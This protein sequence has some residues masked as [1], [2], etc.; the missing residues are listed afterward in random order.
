[1]RSAVPLLSAPRTSL[2]PNP[3]H[4]A[5]CPPA[6]AL[7]MFLALCGLP[8]VAQ[9][10]VQGRVLDA[11][12]DEP[13]PF[14]AVHLPSG[15]HGVGT[16]LGGRFTLWVPAGADSLRVA[17]MGYRPA[18]VAV[19]DSMLVRLE[20]AVEQLRA[21]VVRPGEN[22]ALRLVEGAIAAR[23]RNH[24]PGRRAHRY[25][26]YG[27][28]VF[29]LAV[30]SA[31]LADSTRIA[32]LPPDDRQA[33]RFAQRQH[34]L[35]MESAT[36]CTARPPAQRTEE[37]LAMR[38]SGLKD[39]ALL[40]MAASSRTWSIYDPL[41]E[42]N[43]RRFPSP[44]AP[45]AT[46]RYRYVL[47]DTLVQ[48]G[49]TVF[50]IR[51][52]PRK[53]ARFDG[54]RGVLGLH[55]GDHAVHHVEA[56]PA[57]QREGLGMRMRQVHRRVGDTWFPEQV[58]STLFLNALKVGSYALVGRVRMDLTDIELD[59]DLP[60]SAF[61]GAD[62]V[63]DRMEVR[64]DAALWDSLRTVPLDAKDL[65]TYRT[66]DSLGRAEKL[67]RTVRGLDALLRGAIPWGPV[68]LP[69][70]RLIAYNGHEGFRLGLGLRTNARM[71]RR[72]VLDGYAAHGFGD[73]ATKYGGGLTLRP[74]PD[75]DHELRLAARHDVLETGGWSFP[76]PPA[77]LG[78]ESYRDL[79][80]TRMDA[81]DQLEAAV[82]VRVLEGLKLWLG[83]ERTD[84]SDRTGYR[85]AT[86]VG[87]GI[88]LH[89]RRFVTGAMT[90]GLRLAP[91]ER[92]ARLPGRHAVTRPGRPELQVVAWRAFDGLWGGGRDLWRVVLQL[93]D[94]HRGALR[95]LA[96]RV[97]AGAADPQAPAPFLFNLRGTAT[98]DLGVGTPWAFETMA[99]NSFVADRFAALHLRLGL[100]P[101]LWHHRYS[102]PVP[103][104]IASGVLGALDHPVRHVGWSFAA[105]TDGYQEVG[106]ALDR[107]LRSGVV[108]LG[109]LGAVRLGPYATGRLD[110][111]AA[112]KLTLSL[113]L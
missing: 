10:T 97:V 54:L 39:P 33:V 48:A 52:F 57:E 16:D 74:W 92:T 73:R 11:R 112:V 103:V 5:S 29:T 80:I 24:G 26:S 37:V 85:F 86:A 17:C 56:E 59:P 107:L 13:V 55:A 41:I 12:S 106:L 2:P 9:R 22:P 75:R 61:R 42:L 63:A 34:V 113:A 89:D 35:L 7:A 3:M 27:R 72:L 50:T 70:D 65:L 77:L 82:G 98:H 68:E 95:W 108:G 25:T 38:V 96:W 69:L 14:A 99:P 51:F 83:T 94:V 20:P 102:Q 66:I 19:A 71:S 46:E 31:L 30:D 1:M 78:E 28:T 49:D 90:F 62:L 21:V 91:G 45:G 93:G 8:T 88:T 104:L 60:P 100:G 47:E 58:E 84:R 4:A 101:V 36:R 87:D 79:Y 44:I 18:V 81:V 64:T 15:K 110:D 23:D 53:G 40:A 76:R 43:E 32:A 105:P 109:V 111:D 6:A 67:D